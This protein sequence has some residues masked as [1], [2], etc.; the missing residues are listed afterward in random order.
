M[1]EVE[2]LHVGLIDPAHGERQFADRIGRNQQVEVV[3]HQDERVQR[4]A[5][6]AESSAEQAPEVVAVVR[7]E[8]DRT[9]VDAA[10]RDMQ[11]S[12]PRKS[13]PR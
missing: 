1:S 4:N 2:C 6:I 11:L 12:T 10:L 3:V 13:V 8:E 7:I 5:M 9:L